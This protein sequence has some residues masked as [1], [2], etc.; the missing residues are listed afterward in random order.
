MPKEL[1]LIAM[2]ACV[3]LVGIYQRRRTGHLA[4]T[5]KRAVATVMENRKH[6]RSMDSYV[7]YPTIRFI[8]EDGTWITQEL[9]TGYN[10]GKSVG[11]KMNII[12]DPLETSEVE[13]D[14]FVHLKVLP[15]VL[16]FAGFLGVCFGI[17]EL[18]GVIDLISG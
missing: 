14:S 6:T 9:N 2:S 15:V 17:L 8:A 12:Y 3:F 11:S 18:L 5:G 13:I 4:S 7:Y 10:P 1:F 16:T